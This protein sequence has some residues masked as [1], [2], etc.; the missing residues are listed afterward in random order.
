MYD[1]TIDKLPKYHSRFHFFKEGVTGDP[2][3]A[4]LE[5]LSNLLRRNGHQ[6]SQNLLLKMDI[7]GYEW[8]VFE[9]TPS[10]VI[11][12]FSQIVIELHGLNPN[13]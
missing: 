12:Q 10:A 9:E 1:H 13:K 3:E 6:A 7:E 5:T 4:G 2:D 11:G 8:A